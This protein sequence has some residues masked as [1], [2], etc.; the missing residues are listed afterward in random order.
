MMSALYSGQF[1]FFIQKM[2]KKTR[3]L[4]KISWEALEWERDHGI[5]PKFLQ[6]LAIDIQEIQK[7]D[8]EVAIVLGWGNIFRGIAWAANWMNRTAADY[9][10]MLAT[11]M[12][13][14]AFRDALEQAWSNA[15][16][17]SALDIPEIGDRYVQRKAMSRLTKWD[18]VICV[19]GTWNPYFTTDSGWVLRALELECD[20]MVKATR[21]DWVFDKDPEKN[22]DAVMI[23]ESSYEEVLTKDIRVMDHTGITLAKDWWM[24]L[25]V[26]N[27]YK[28]WA[29][30][31]A[32][33]WEKEWT[34]IS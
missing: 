22:D 13:G 16:I 10:G 5:D 19:G 24:V 18:I 14:I 3:V 32:I 9:M 34:T 7:N 29:I 17:M 6:K 2:S 4:I 20:M 28:K 25:K 11:I 15:Y 12:N 21:V 30:L 23:Q 33:Q 27:L 26:V 8:I 31:R 1:I